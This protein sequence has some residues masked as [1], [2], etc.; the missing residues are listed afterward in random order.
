[1]R[2]IITITQFHNI[3][4]IV[5]HHLSITVLQQLVKPLNLANSNFWHC[6][7]AVDRMILTLSIRHSSWDGHRVISSEDLFLKTRRKKSS[8][9][10]IIRWYFY[11][12]KIENFFH[13]TCR[14]CVSLTLTL[15]CKVFLPETRQ[16][17]HACRHLSYT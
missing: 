13:L 4:E 17:V 12:F 9:Y 14:D 15:N 10:K 16:T 7:R 8:N 5:H 6:R 11:A 3:S 2:H 1:M